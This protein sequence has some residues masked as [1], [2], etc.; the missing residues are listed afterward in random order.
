M[1]D[2]T[3]ELN[4]GFAALDAGQLDEAQAAGEAA[5]ALDSSS[6]HAHFILFQVKTRR[7]AAE[8]PP[9]PEPAPVA[10]AAAPA[11]VDPY[12]K[13]AELH[14]TRPKA[15]GADESLIA[16]LMDRHLDG[17]VDMTLSK[18]LIQ[19]PH[20]PIAGTAYDSQVIV[21]AIV[22]AAGAFFIWDSA[23]ISTGAFGA[24]FAFYLLFLRGWQ[25]RRVARFLS[26]EFRKDVQK[27]YQ[28]WSF[29]GVTLTDKA[30]GNVCQSPEGDWRAFG[31]EIKARMDGNNGG[32]ATQS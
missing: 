4:R 15:P 2:L 9:A 11:E 5:L 21:A 1:T 8:A 24:V 20:S 32:A 19:H 13:T 31:T 14:R 17:T 12:A 3:T 10:E 25:S 18:R 6:V 29:G 30:T 23:L 28:S 22:V 16:W 26:K 27:W 7:A